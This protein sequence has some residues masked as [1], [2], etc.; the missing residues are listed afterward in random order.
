MAAGGRAAHL[1]WKT[2][3]DAHHPGRATSLPHAAWHH[4]SH[5]GL[6]QMSPSDHWR[7]DCKGELEILEMPWLQSCDLLSLWDGAIQVKIEDQELG[8]TCIRVFQKHT[9]S[10]KKIS[11][12]HHASTRE[13]VWR[14]P[15]GFLISTIFKGSLSH[16]KFDHFYIV[17]FHSALTFLD[18]DL[19]SEGR[20]KIYRVKMV[21]LKVTW[22]PLKISRNHKSFW[23]PSN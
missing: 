8:T 19:W 22:G 2:R 5:R 17:D 13:L 16:L 9:F 21:K 12:T 11:A 10:N 3:S 7:M 23:I 18:R 1:S 14:Y 20:V 6:S 4:L 15:K